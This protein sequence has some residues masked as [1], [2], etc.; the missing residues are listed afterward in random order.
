MAFH[1]ILR[2]SGDYYAAMREARTISANMTN[3]I[4]T[5]LEKIGLNATDVKVFPYRFVTALI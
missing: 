1:T 3:M 5:N 4:Q 2:T